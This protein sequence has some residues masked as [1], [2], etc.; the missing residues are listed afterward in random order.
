MPAV[1]SAANR[2]LKLSRSP[3]A[4]VAVLSGMNGSMGTVFSPPDV[5]PGTASNRPSPP[6]TTAPGRKV[7]F[8][9]TT[10]SL[11]PWAK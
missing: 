2:P 6:S 7:S 11:P 9:P 4:F 10:S 1:R 8:P 5:L 3:A